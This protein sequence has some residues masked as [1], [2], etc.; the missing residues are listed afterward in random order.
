MNAREEIFPPKGRVEFVQTEWARGWGAASSGFAE[1][2]RVL[3]KRAHRVGPSVDQV[4][5][6]VFFL[7]RH[8]VELALKQLLDFLGQEFEPKHSLSYL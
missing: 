2:A 6:V 5:L 8:R 7:Q 3:T 4:G 1:A